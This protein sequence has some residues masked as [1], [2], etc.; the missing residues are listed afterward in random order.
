MSHGTLFTWTRTGVFALGVLLLPLSTPSF[1][2]TTAPT[3]DTQRVTTR[4]E[5]DHT[6]WWGLVGLAGL[7][8]LMGRR[9]SATVQTYHNTGTPE[10]SR[11]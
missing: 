11:T 8:G 1:A 2:Q 3:P 5:R 6:G 4:E 9:H 7:F 10:R